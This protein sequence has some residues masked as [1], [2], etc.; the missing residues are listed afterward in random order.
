M[1]DI[2]D[3][4][5]IKPSKDAE[6]FTR[7]MLKDNEM[8]GIYSPSTWEP[9]SDKTYYCD[10]CEEVIPPASHSY[11]DDFFNHLKFEEDVEPFENDSEECDIE[12][13]IVANCTFRDFI[14]SPFFEDY[15]EESSRGIEFK[16]GNYKIVI[17]SEEEMYDTFNIISF[18]KDFNGKSW[19]VGEISEE[20]VDD[21][22]VRLIVP[23]EQEKGKLVF[24]PLIIDR[25]EQLTFAFPLESDQLSD[26]FN[27]IDD[28]NTEYFPGID[29]NLC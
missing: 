21:I 3:F 11:S 28:G 17:S 9:G 15:S 18:Y 25:S 14:H 16:N 1:E 12:D 10:H 22:D 24:S 29:S 4:K 7:E 26:I 23:E 20:Q 6:T 27:N 13:C 2:L 8:Q 5:D 19:K